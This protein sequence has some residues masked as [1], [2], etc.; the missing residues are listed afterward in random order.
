MPDLTDAEKAVGRAFRTSA[1]AD[2]DKLNAEKPPTHVAPFYI[3]IFRH[4]CSGKGGQ[5]TPIRLDEVYVSSPAA[6]DE[7]SGVAVPA[8]RVGFLYRQGLCQF[9]KAVARSRV[10]HVVDAWKRPPLS[11]RVA[12]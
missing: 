7:T 12:R 5:S 10:G 3:V 2:L 8:G 9:C 11:K 1:Q 6:V 4:D